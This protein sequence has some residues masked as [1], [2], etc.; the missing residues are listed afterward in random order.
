MIANILLASGQTISPKSKIQ[1]F[2]PPLT[3]P[4]SSAPEEQFN[5]TSA[6]DQFVTSSPN[7]DIVSE[8]M[9]DVVVYHDIKWQKP[10]LPD[11]FTLI[12]KPWPAGEEDPLVEFAPILG[13]DS[14]DT[15]TTSVVEL[16]DDPEDTDILLDIFIDTI[17]DF[18]NETETVTDGP[19][20]I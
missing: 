15:N 3:L 2:G 11:N 18:L 10:P 12:G 14:L 1:L 20:V 17:N 19:S 5:D 16:E 7:T 6:S 8:E 9:N 4:P 13:P